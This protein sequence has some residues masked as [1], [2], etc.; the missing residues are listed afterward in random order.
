MILL[1]SLFGTT[2]IH[3]MSHTYYLSTL[4]LISFFKHLIWNWLSAATATVVA[5]VVSDKGQYLFFNYCIDTLIQLHCFIFLIKYFILSIVWLNTISTNFVSVASKK[6]GLFICSGENLFLHFDSFYYSKIYEVVVWV[7][8]II[9]IHYFS[10]P[11][12][13]V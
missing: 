9:Y 3:C 13:N 10:F 11:F 1:F 8:L 2:W 4:F 7:I 12:S 5:P 6:I